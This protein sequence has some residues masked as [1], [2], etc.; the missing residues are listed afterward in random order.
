MPFHPLDVL[1]LTIGF[2]GLYMAGINHI[3]Q[4]KGKPAWLVSFYGFGAGGIGSI[5][6]R[7]MIAKTTGK[8]I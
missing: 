5:I 3:R 6:L 1:L 8:V 7:L 2:V 4:N